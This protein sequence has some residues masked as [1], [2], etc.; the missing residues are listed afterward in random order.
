MTTTI[1]NGCHDF[2]RMWSQEF[3][4]HEIIRLHINSGMQS[5]PALTQFST[6]ASYRSRGK[7]AAGKEAD[8]Q[9]HRITLPASG[10]CVRRG[11]FSN[12]K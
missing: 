9:I 8:R 2:P 6:S 3:N 1:A 4:L 5:H 10:I 12:W 7:P 11:H